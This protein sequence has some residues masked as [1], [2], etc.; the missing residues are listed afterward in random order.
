MFN[1]P[2][3]IAMVM[4]VALLIFGPKKLPELGKSV[5][6]GLKNFKR[7]MSDVTEEVKSAVNS[8]ETAKPATSEK[9][10]ETAKPAEEQGS[11]AK[12]IT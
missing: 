6:L 12:I 10:A 5:G 11:V 3:D 2:V 1:S 8:D 4:G 7:A 9:P